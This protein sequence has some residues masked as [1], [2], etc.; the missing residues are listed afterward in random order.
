[1]TFVIIL[2]MSVT[3]ALCVKSKLFSIERKQF[4]FV[5]RLNISVNNFSIMSGWSQGF[6]ALMCLAQAHNTVTPVGIKHKTS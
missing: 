3:D 6:L 5:L 2:M 4:V 1:M